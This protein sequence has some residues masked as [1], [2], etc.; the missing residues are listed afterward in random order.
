MP[1]ARL[2]QGP[3]LDPGKFQDPDVTA[4][5]ESAPSWR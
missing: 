2:A 1:E 4:K 5:G 3:P